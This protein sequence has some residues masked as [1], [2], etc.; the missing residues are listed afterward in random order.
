MSSFKNLKQRLS[1]CGPG[2]RKGSG[3]KRDQRSHI[4]KWSLTSSALVY[5]MLLDR[6]STTFI[7]WWIVFGT[8]EASLE[9]K[10]LETTDLKH[11][12]T[13]LIIF[14]MYRKALLCQTLKPKPNTI[15]NLQLF[16]VRSEVGRTHGFPSS[17]FGPI[18]EPHNTELGWIPV[19]AA[20]C[21]AVYRRER[22]LII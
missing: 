16:L 21:C 15:F 13:E 5:V 12:G 11:S 20:H 9:W 3:T 4:T 6:S 18:F 22:G 8:I 14:F 10:R 7:S 1:K 19:G 2:D 17:V